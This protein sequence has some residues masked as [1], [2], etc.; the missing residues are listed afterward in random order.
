MKK[1]FIGSTTYCYP[2]QTSNLVQDYGVL[3]VYI[4]KYFTRDE[5]DKIICELIMRHPYIEHSMWIKINIEWIDGSVRG[6]YH[7]LSFNNDNDEKQCKGSLSIK[8]EN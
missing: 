2:Y 5:M 1:Y 4:G 8:Y 7:M 3:S 6:Y